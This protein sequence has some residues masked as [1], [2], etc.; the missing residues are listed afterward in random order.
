MIPPPGRF[1]HPH[2]QQPVF[3][4]KLPGQLVMLK[5][6]RH[7][8]LHIHRHIHLLLQRLRCLLLPTP[9]VPFLGLSL[10]QAVHQKLLQH[11]H[12]RQLRLLLLLPLRRQNQLHL[13]LRTLLMFIGTS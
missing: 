8:R 12:L 11:R 2:Q 10:H 5:L 13:S 3:R 6:G 9:Q 4:H 7:H 1:R